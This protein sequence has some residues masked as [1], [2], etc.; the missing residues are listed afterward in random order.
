[1]PHLTGSCCTRY[2]GEEL[3]TCNVLHHLVCVD[4]IGEHCEREF[5][6]CSFE[7][8]GYIKGN[9]VYPPLRC[10]PCRDER[11]KLKSSV[12]TC[13]ICGRVFEIKA[14][15]KK[16]WKT[17]GLT[18]PVD[19]YIIKSKK[20]GVECRSC[21]NLDENE[22]AKAKKLYEFRRQTDMKQQKFIQLLRS[23]NPEL[24]QKI[25]E[26]RLRPIDVA[27]V[28]TRYDEK[29][30]V[31]GFAYRKGKYTQVT[32]EKH[33]PT[34]HIYHRGDHSV[35]TTPKGKKLGYTFTKVPILGPPYK[36]TYSPDFRKVTSI[37]FEEYKSNVTYDPQMK[38]KMGVSLAGKPLG[39]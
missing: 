9:L 35:L 15:T 25:L 31:I 6:T 34:M 10:R 5:D 12:H 29:F 2:E 4:K 20:F 24:R 38:T 16:Y 18:G 32:D 27:D 33:N 21:R 28:V 23:R 19:R 14:I 36:K 7:Q 39:R 17:S 3:Q 30:N 26:G 13:G 37:T 1:M 22:K 8:Y 11:K